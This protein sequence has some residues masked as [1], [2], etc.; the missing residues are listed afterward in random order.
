MLLTIFWL[1]LGLYV[2]LSLFFVPL[3]YRFL[4]AIKKEE[5]KNKSRGNI[6][7]EMYD[8]MGAGEL[9]LHENMQ[10]NPI[11]FLANFLA[12]IIYRGRH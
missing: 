3:P 11:F 2:L 10:G 9:A 1:I 12:L 5:A 4:A 8:S 7:G 6:Q